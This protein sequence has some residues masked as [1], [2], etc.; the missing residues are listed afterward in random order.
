VSRLFPA[1]FKRL[2]DFISHVLLGEVV[3]VALIFIVLVSQLACEPT[4]TPLH[5]PFV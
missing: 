3:M 1:G 4:A 5:T 2:K